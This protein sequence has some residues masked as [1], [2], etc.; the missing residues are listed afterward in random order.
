MVD[1]SRHSRHIL[2]PQVGAQGQAKLSQAKVVCIGAGGLGSPVLQYLAAAGIGEITIIDDDIVELSN[3]QRQV[4]HRTQDV[5]IPKVESAKRFIN[6]L[7]ANIIVNIHNERL[8][9]NNAK[10]LIKGHD[11][12]IDGTDNLPTRYLIDDTCKKLE[13]PW[14]Y[15]SVYR[16]E[17]Q[18]SVFNLNHGPIYRDLF[19]VPPPNDLIPSCSDAGVLGVL[20]GMVGSIQASEVIKIIIGIGQPL[21]GRLLLIDAMDMSMKTLSFSGS[22]RDKVE[23]SKPAAV[24]SMFHSITAIDA[25]SKMDAGWKPYFIDVRSKLENKKYKISCVDDFCMHED[26]L[27][28]VNRIPKDRDILV[29]C[30]AGQ[31]SQ[32]AIILLLQAGYLGERLFNLDGG[33]I[34]W[35]G[36]DPEGIIYG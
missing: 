27:S 36:V 31:R 12:L 15:G 17:G 20:P 7:D 5:G 18:V 35:N 22:N 16:F 23:E 13:I 28:A 19:P 9:E 2:L 1:L 30:K 14:V 33:I 21:V 10:A 3:L 24:E 25:K 8:V 6:Q 4:I 11:V 26:I 34:A 32:V 29:H